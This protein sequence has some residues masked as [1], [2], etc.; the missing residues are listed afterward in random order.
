LRELGFR[1]PT[2]EELARLGQ[3]EPP[4]PS[5]SAEI[6][7]SLLNRAP[8]ISYS[9]IRRRAPF[10][11]A[12]ITAK[13]LG[14]RPVWF[15]LSPTWSLEDEAIGE[16]IRAGAI[17]HR[18]HCPGH[19]LIFVCNAPDE[20]SI[21]RRQGE[22]AFLYNKTA[23]LPESVFRPL[24]KVHVE[25]DAVY[26]ARLVPWKRHELS[27]AIRR[28]AFIYYRTVADPSPELCEAEIIARHTAAAPEHVFINAVD[29]NGW[30][31]RLAQHEVNE[32]LN[33]A[34]VGLCLS[35]IEGA[36]YAST[37]YLLA[38]LAVVTTPNLGGR[39]VYYDEEYCLTVPPDQRS[40]AEAVQAL[41]ARQIPR[42]Y[43]RA[44]T[45]QRIEKDRSRFLSLL[46]GI[47]SAEGADHRFAMPWPFKDMLLMNWLPVADAADRAIYGLV[48]TQGQRSR[49]YYVRRKWLRR[50][51][52][53]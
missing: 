35:E 49:G 22:A 17:R 43:I 25:F 18:V 28:C 48:D 53:L 33:R 40:I 29:P 34:S 46:N 44:K 10:G 36:M 32:I 27:L 1:D 7:A 51:T 5:F 6:P 38:G 50:L 47:L 45:L 8:T 12:S 31:V 20:V 42:D 2:N 11:L 13:A 41:K 52:G 9:S 16:K 19:N 24:P 15:L 21:L 30:P 37:E 3:D 23:N 26:N 14:S 4:P 39:S